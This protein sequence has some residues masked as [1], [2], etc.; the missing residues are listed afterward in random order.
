MTNGGREMGGVTMCSATLRGHMAGRSV[1]LFAGS[2]RKGR[3]LA[4][5]WDWV[6]ESKRKARIGRV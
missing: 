6:F 3:K 4:W 1:Q 2:G 5:D